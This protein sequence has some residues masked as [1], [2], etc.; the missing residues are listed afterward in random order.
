MY[1]YPPV[2]QSAWPP[3]PTW[4]PPAEMLEVVYPAPGPYA[5]RKDARRGSL[6]MASLSAP[7]MSMGFYGAEAVAQAPASVPVPPAPV[8]RAKPPADGRPIGKQIAS[9][10]KKDE[11]GT[12][13]AEKV[14]A[15]AMELASKK[16]AAAAPAPIVVQAP[17][18]PAAP[19]GASPIQLAL[20]G[21]VAVG[22]GVGIGYAFGRTR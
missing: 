18:A 19:A 14:A 11:S 4:H 2:Y 16:Q 13:K 21:L 12:S 5:R 22:V 15:R 3:T 6:A 9:F 20:V 10:F 17:A 1:A 8:K 7:M